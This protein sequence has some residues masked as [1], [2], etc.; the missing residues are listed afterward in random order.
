MKNIIFIL[1]IFL[2][3]GMAGCTKKD[4]ECNMP[5]D[6]A[7]SSE[8]EALAQYIETNSIDAQKDARGFY[9]KIDVI[10]TGDH[11]NT[12][13]EVS[14]NYRGTLTDGTVFDHAQNVRFELKGLIKGWQAGIPLIAKGGKLTLYLPPSL[15]Y[16][17]KATNGI[18]ANSILIF[19]IELIKV[20]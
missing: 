10:G 6:A 12:C 18:P 16:G 11:P 2:A 17:S 15:G 14:V 8:V 7:P 19:S 1:A 4:G 9:Y 13:S 3:A 5:I 20:Y